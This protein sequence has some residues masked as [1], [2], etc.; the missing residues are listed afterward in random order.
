MAANSWVAD[1][2]VALRGRW[3]FLVPRVFADAFAGAAR[4]RRVLL[5]LDFRT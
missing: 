4:R 1:C 2:R 5:E 3:G